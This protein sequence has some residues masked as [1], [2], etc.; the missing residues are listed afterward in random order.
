MGR[1]LQNKQSETG[2]MAKYTLSC[3]V[4]LGKKREPFLG[5]TIFG[6]A[7]TKKG[8]KG[9]TEGWSLSQTSVDHR[10]VKLNWHRTSWQKRD[11]QL[12]T[13][14]ARVTCESLYWSYVV[15]G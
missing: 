8:K 7:A 2:G 3:S 1:W 10:V 14:I 12:M 15:T 4:I 9:A 6:G 5:K 11:G 13:L